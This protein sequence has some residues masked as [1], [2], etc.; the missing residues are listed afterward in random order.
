MQFSLQSLLLS[1]IVVWTAIAAFGAWGIALAVGMLGIAF[2]FRAVVFMPQAVK[3]AWWV[4][5]SL[6]FSAS[7]IAFLAPQIESA[8]HSSAYASSLNHLNM[9]KLALEGYQKNNGSFPPAFI[10]NA[11]GK[12]MVSWRTLLL[13]FLEENALYAQY[14]Q[15]ESWDGPSNSKLPAPRELFTWASYCESPTAFSCL[16]VVGTNTAWRGADPWKPSDLPDGGKHTIVLVET[17]NSAI[18]WS[19]PRDLTVE[20]AIRAIKAG[21]HRR[22]R[23]YFYEEQ[24]G[25]TAV[26]LGDGRVAAI[27]AQTPRETLEALLTINGKEPPVEVDHLFESVGP[28]AAPQ[29]RW[30]RIVSLLVLSLSYAVLLFRP[31]RRIVVV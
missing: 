31:I 11:N 13:P 19:E 6:F 18:P 1:L 7:T 2:Y 24:P 8:M 29:L 27:P 21:P 9:I 26:V 15:K 14:N 10:A 25:I 3:K 12:P 23:G 28:Q 5:A 20:E 22:D 17:M 30:D 16:A 4:L